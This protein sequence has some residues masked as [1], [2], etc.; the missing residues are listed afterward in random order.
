[1]S[2]HVGASRLKDGPC[3]SPND[4]AWNQGT[5]GHLSRRERTKCGEVERHI[6]DDG[7]YLSESPEPEV[8]P[9][10]R[11]KTSERGS[12]D[13]ADCEHDAQNRHQKEEQRKHSD[14]HRVRNLHGEVPSVVVTVLLDDAEDK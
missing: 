12:E 9:S 13:Q 14:E 4:H 1:M 5:R 6:N 10:E 2:D 7:E 11:A 8:V 3:H